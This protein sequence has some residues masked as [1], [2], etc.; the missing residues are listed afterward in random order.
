MSRNNQG[1]H[2][3]R[4]PKV[5]RMLAAGAGMKFNPQAAQPR[6]Y[7]QITFLGCNTTIQPMVDDKMAVVG[8]QLLIQ[9]RQENIE[10]ILPFNGEVLAVWSGM[11]VNLPPMGEVLQPQM[12][13]QI[14]VEEALQDPRDPHADRFLITDRD[15]GDE[16][17]EFS[18]KVGNDQHEPMPDLTE[19]L[20]A[21]DLPEHEADRG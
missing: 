20:H 2:P 19:G 9:D 4:D 3:A 13:A 15:T 11:L 16:A 5:E 10:Y 8:Y 21:S 14:T 17:E 1:G 7:R 18:K 12:P 6:T